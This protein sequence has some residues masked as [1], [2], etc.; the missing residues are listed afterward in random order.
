MK[1]TWKI[2]NSEV[3]DCGFGSPIFMHRFNVESKHQA[4]WQEHQQNKYNM[5]TIFDSAKIGILW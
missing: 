1:Y 2:V 4:I 5:Q 3:I